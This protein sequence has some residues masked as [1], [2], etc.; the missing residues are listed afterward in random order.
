LDRAACWPRARSSWG[1][2]W[3]P[4]SAGL[5]PRPRSSRGQAPRQRIGR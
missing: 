2:C 3:A 4:P 5:D 1:S